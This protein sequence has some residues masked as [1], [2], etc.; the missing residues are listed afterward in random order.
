[1]ITKDTAKS[2][3]CK[4]KIIWKLLKKRR[5][6]NKKI[7]KD[8]RKL[9]E[10]ITTKFKRKYSSEKLLQ[11]QGDAKKHGRFWKKWSENL[12]L[13]TQNYRAKLSLRYMLSLRKSVLQMYS[14]MFSLI[15]V[16]NLANNIPRARRSFKS[17]VWK[18][19]ETIK[20]WVSYH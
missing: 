20:G 14:T 9:F 8:Y 7:Y 4:T 17:Y 15:L 6:E 16:P 1:M 18:T 19:K 2:Y 12:N 13:F 10:T 5:F 3:K 11:F